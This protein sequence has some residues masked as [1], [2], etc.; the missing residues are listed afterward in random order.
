MQPVPPWSST[1]SFDADG[2]TVAG[3]TAGSLAA[4][5]GTPLVVVDEA[6]LRARCRAFAGSFPRV[7]WAV[8]A[9]PLRALIRTALDEGLGL[10]AATGG[11]VD[12][13]LRAGAP[14]GSIV[15]HGNNKLDA[16]IEEAVRA[17]VGTLIVDN[18]EELPRI[19]S[20]AE[21]AGIRQPVLVRVAPGLD[22]DTHEFVKTGA[23][24]TKFGIPIAGGLALDALR[25]AL[26]IGT[27]DVLGIHLHVGS[28]LLDTRPYGAAV[29]VALDFLA[30]ARDAV[31]FEARILDVGGGMGTAYTDEDP[32]EAEA[33]G[34]D[35]QAR[36][37]KGCADRGLP[38][39]ELVV[40]PGRAVTSGAALTLYRVGTVKDVPDVRRFVAVDGGMSDN[41]RPA[42]YGARYTLELASRPASSDLHP[43][44]VVGRH[45]ESGDVLARDV[46]LPSDIGPGD[47]LAVASTG[48]YE[49]AMASAYNR[50]GRPAVVLVSDGDA[51]LIAR[52][53]SYDDLS[54]LD[55]DRG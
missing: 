11:E 15:F 1:A 49:Y 50:V 42:L 2:L 12:A 55:V 13:C 9:F 17:G 35:L 14:G 26:D 54:R 37:E 33:L 30:E 39:P 47:L 23:P 20:A 19:G 44:T 22:V 53:E 38:L 6:D 7:L 40:E 52:R 45:C 51:R 21:A 29:D 36:L 48:A 25:Q 5:F 32:V 3:R 28:Q 10:L 24:D 18:A 34:I 43:V 46:E 8:K 41:I 4:E 27:L 31:R 16:E